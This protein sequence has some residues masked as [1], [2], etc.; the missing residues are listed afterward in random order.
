VES[1]KM[2][3]MNLASVLYIVSKSSS[4]T[5]SPHPV[6]EAETSPGGVYHLISCSGDP[7]ALSCHEKTHIV[8]VA[9]L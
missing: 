8:E 7:W 2:M 9:V 6:S 3:Q 4:S 5:L 1:K